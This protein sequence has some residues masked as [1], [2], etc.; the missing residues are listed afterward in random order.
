MV[1]APAEG[2]TLW[3]Q[4]RDRRQIGALVAAVAVE[5]VAVLDVGAIANCA[6]AAALPNLPCDTFRRLKYQVMPKI[7]GHS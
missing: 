5:I 6:N 1:P 7:S 2:L 3:G 4:V